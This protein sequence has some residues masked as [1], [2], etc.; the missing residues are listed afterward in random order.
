MTG[1]QNP[2]NRYAGK[3]YN[4][5]CYKK[6]SLGSDNGPAVETDT[7]VPENSGIEGNLIFFDRGN[8]KIKD[9]L[10]TGITTTIERGGETGHDEDCNICEYLLSL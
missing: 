3:R 8:S 4:C 6:T 10:K 2:K 9:N 1:K 7:A 5:R